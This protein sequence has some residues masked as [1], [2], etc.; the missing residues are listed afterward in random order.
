MVACNN[1][2]V[3]PAFLYAINYHLKF[4]NN[5]L[6]CPA[7]SQSSYIQ[8]LQNEKKDL[9]KRKIGKIQKENR[10]VVFQRREGQET[11]KKLFRLPDK[12]LYSTG[13]L[14][15]ILELVAAYKGNSP[16][17]LKCFIDMIK[18]Y[19]L[20]RGALLQKRQQQ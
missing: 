11:V 8:E 3:V 7:A 15:H 18:W 4:T 16:S 2:L 19:L 6:P 1:V 14:N 17:D 10:S 5:L 9:T 13:T 20:V 12:H